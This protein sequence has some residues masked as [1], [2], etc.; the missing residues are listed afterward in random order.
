MLTFSLF[1]AADASL[2]TRT[3]SGPILLDRELSQRNIQ[4]ENTILLEKAG[5]SVWLTGI[6]E[7]PEDSEISLYFLME[8]P[9][10]EETFL[11]IKEICWEGTSLGASG[12]HTLTPGTRML[13]RSRLR[14]VPSGSAGQISLEIVTET[15]GSQTC[16]VSLNPEGTTAEAGSR[17]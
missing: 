1:N 12:Y 13:T 5:L 14:G 15:G 7:G 16:T 3:E 10:E 8:N 6:S 17:Q 11:Y 2:L 4:S 9:S